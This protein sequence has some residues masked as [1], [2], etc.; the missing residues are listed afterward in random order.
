MTADQDEHSIDKA[1]KR[2]FNDATSTAIRL[3]CWIAF[4]PTRSGKHANDAPD[5]GLVGHISEAR[6][7]V[8]PALFFCSHASGT[9][10]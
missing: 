10:R 6:S 2:R 1:S 8:L 5:Q 7:L 9:C 4:G 3:T